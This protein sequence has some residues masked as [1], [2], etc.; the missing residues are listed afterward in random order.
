MN[1]KLSELRKKAMSLPLTP[2]VYLMKDKNGRI[3]YVGKA[4]ALKNR[5]STYFGSQNNHTVKVRK[6][7]ENVADFDYIMTD[8]EFEALVLECSLIKQHSPK[9]NILLKD[10]KGY[11]YIKITDSEWKTI[12]AVKQKLDDGARYIGPYTGAFAVSNTVDEAKKIFRLPQCSKV[13]PRDCG[14]S[15]PCLNFHISQCSAPCAGKVTVQ[16]HN[17]AVEQAISFIVNGSD[18]VIKDLEEKMEAAADSLEFEKAAKLRD[19]INA[20]RKIGEK[21][22]VVA[23]AVKEQDVFAIA[24]SASSQEHSDTAKSCLSVLRFSDG[25]LYDSEHFFFDMPENFPEARAELIRSYYS[26]RSNVPARVSVDG[27]VEGAELLGEWLTSIR[28]KKVTVAVPQRGEQSE[29]IRMCHANAVQKLAIYMGKT[30]HS[31][32]ALDELKTLLNLKTPPEFI[33]AYDISHTAG[34]DNVA[35]MIVFKNGRPYKKAYRRFAVK[36]FD[37][38][39][40]YGSMREVISRRFNRY[41]E[42]KE[43]GEGFGVLPDLILLDGGEGQVNAVKPVIEAFGLDVPVFGMVK[44]SSHRTR[45]ITAD[46]REIAIS[47]VRQ[48]FTLVSSI[49]EE[50]HRFAITY[51]K[52]KH[53]KGLLSTRLTAIE[54]IGKKKAELLIKHFR[55]MSALSEA[56]IEKLSEVKGISKKDA[57]NIYAYFHKRKSE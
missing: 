22:K 55:S 34:S 47:A 39:D 46:G 28:G 14:K 45:A 31:T 10:D 20:I 38:Q 56:S 50:V 12:S 2:G 57:E 33:E 7:V 36:S 11:H 3:I 16:M 9:Y 8:S 26:M 13:F 43:S 1:E 48:V 19:K 40:D 54:G 21:Q 32:A 25:R 15:R 4:K 37:G 30:G 6:M 44:D 23:A 41:I 49:Q 53:G 29:L 42:E 5:V 24:S 17:E 18:A 35:G 52:E 51:H 27:E